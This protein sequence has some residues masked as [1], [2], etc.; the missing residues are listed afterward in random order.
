MT[1][2]KKFRRFLPQA[3][4]YTFTILSHIRGGYNR[5]LLL[6][7]VRNVETLQFRSQDALANT[8]INQFLIKKYVKSIS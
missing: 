8:K 7:A 2:I 5:Y 6:D 1:S 3:G 4:R